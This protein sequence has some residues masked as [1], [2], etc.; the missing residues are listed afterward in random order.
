MKKME[1]K[2]YQYP[3]GVNNGGLLNIDYCPTISCSSW[4]NNCLLVEIKEDEREDI[5]DCR[6]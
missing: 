1:Y 2:M 3:R 5:Q 4:E 6:K